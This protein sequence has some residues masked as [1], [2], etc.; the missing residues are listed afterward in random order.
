MVCSCHDNQPH[1]NAN[2]DEDLIMW[3][4]TPGTVFKS[5]A[6]TIGNGNIQSFFLGSVNPEKIRFTE[7]SLLLHKKN[8]PP[9][10]DKPVVYTSMGTFEI[11]NLTNDNAQIENYKRG[12]DL[13]TGR[14]FVE[15]SCNGSKY[16]RTFFGNVPDKVMVY[17]FESDKQND[18]VITFASTHYT[19]AFQ[20]VG[21]MF[22]KSGYVEDNM[23]KFVINGRID[24]DGDLR[25]S[26]DSI[27]IHNATEFV[28]IHNAATSYNTSTNL[29]DDNYTKK[30]TE[31]ISNISSQYYNQL[32]KTQLQHY[33]SIFGSVEIELGHGKNHQPINLR[34]PNHYNGNN[35]FGL[36]ELMFQY[37]RYVAI[38]YAAVD[39]MQTLSNTWCNDCI[40]QNINIQN[41]DSLLH[42]INTLEQENSYVSLICKM[43]FLS[44]LQEG[45]S[46][47]KTLGK[48]MYPIRTNNNIQKQGIFLNLNTSDGQ[49]ES[50]MLIT[51]AMSE[52][53]LN[54]ETEQVLPALPKNWK[55]GHIKG[56]RS[57]NGNTFNIYWKDNK[58]DKVEKY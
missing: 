49:N 56:L 24:T 4:D 5:E 29:Y 57:I 14:G 3:Y 9:H 43:L 47:I 6:L 21:N 32:A 18:Y 20:L 55:E 48:L 11:Q 40:S 15:Y 23:L 8:T 10:N 50:N 31:I 12:L 27:Y 46:A 33:D 28:I 53:L 37:G 7:H 30:A 26:N 44:K 2:V 45:E 54:A 1:G 42:A 41:R 16:K 34:L 17:K 38:A 22:M 58:L 51:T 39:S 35:D 13:N 52:M 19:S 36:E 25:A